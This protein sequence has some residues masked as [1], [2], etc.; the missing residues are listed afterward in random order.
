MDLRRPR[1]RL[2]LVMLLALAAV[3]A[4]VAVRP[5]VTDALWSHGD[6]LTLAVAWTLALA[7]S[8]WL[9]LAA[10]ACLLALGF[11]RPQ[12][13]RRLAP[14]LPVGLRRLVEVAI[15][16]ACIAVPALPA[17]A[18]D[19]PPTTTLVLADLPVVRAV[20]AV[21]RAPEPAPAP[22]PRASAPV[23]DRVVVR[24]GDNLWLIAR[25]ALARADGARPAD[26]ETAHYWRAVVA[27]NRS[28]LRS[29]D[30][31]LIFVGEIV[32]LPPPATVS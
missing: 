27:A 11:A 3:G 5:P 28:T 6:D 15:V 8:A 26:S 7:A 13:A 31:S 23:A 19:P 2:A 21:E 17:S 4:L 29:G 32:T 14:L 24:P 10:G 25:A 16:S 30:P 12:L 20:A 18:T 9:V 22:T 1:L